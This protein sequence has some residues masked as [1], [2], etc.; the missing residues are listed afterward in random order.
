MVDLC[1]AVFQKQTHVTL[2]H[3]NKGSVVLTLNRSAAAGEH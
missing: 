3:Y 1:L 2:Y